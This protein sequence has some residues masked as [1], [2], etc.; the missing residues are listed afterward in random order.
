MQ[1]K[2][3]HMRTLRITAWTLV[4]GGLL[5]GLAGLTGCSSSGDPNQLQK[6]WGLSE[7]NRRYN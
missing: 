6:Q 5:A 1:E 3:R 4:A 2:G 7:S